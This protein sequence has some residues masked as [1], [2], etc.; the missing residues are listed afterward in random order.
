MLPYLRSG[1]TLARLGG[2]EFVIL[3]ENIS[4]IND[5][6]QVAQRIQ[7][8]LSLPFKLNDREIYTTVSTGIA[9]SANTYERPE[10]LLR[11]ADTAMYRAKAKGKGCHEVFN[12]SMHTRVLTL[13]HLENDLRRAIE[14]QEFELYYQPIVSLVTGK[15]NG[16]EALVRWQH[17]ERGLVSPLEFIPIAEETG[18][19]LPIGNWVLQ[20]ACRQ[21]RAWQ[22][23]FPEETPLSI[24]VNLSAK[25]F[26][27]PNLFEQ[28]SRTL[29][30]T[31]LDARRLKLEITESAIM[32]NPE[33]AATLMSQLRALG[34]ELYIDDFGTG[35]SSL[36]YLQQ[37][38]VDALKIDRSFI[39]KMGMNGN[40]PELVQTIIMLA[41]N[42]GMDVVSEGV[43]TAEQLAQLRTIECKYGHVQGY[44]FSKPV[45]SEAAAALIINQPQW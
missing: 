2:D 35:Y 15:I 23:Q 31:E 16:F 28:V 30:E 29:Q 27:Q 22:L 42:L 43:E 14:H 32:E 12:S 8:L 5:A 38:Q 34:I 19:I 36:N 9:L 21:L 11:D 7:E 41:R 24:S 33:M 20:S 18:L 17:P 3:L 6:I 25:Q 26:A 10:D 1:D 40:N 44:L 4:D 39:S 45:D 13:L 37:F